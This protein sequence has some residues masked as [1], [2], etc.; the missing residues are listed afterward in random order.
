[1]AVHSQ[2]A[3]TASRHPVIVAVGIAGVM[4]VVFP[5]AFSRFIPTKLRSAL[6]D[7]LPSESPL[8]NFPTQLRPLGLAFVEFAPRWKPSTWGSTGEWP[9]VFRWKA[10]QIAVPETENTKEGHDTN[11]EVNAAREST[12]ESGGVA[13]DEACGVTEDA[14]G[15]AEGQGEQ[16]HHE[17]EHGHE[18]QH[19]DQHHEQ[20]HHEHQPHENHEHQHHE[21]QHHEHEHQEHSG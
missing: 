13:L 18:Q 2:L 12:D 14:N 21:H 4:Q 5:G 6:L 15:G 9:S 20:Q 17:H 10:V 8:L 1:M 7:M 16:Q 19:H 11:V 3:Q